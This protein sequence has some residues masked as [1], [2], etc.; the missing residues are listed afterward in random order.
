[1]VAGVAERANPE[2]Q[3]FANAK[4]DWSRDA[5]RAAIDDDAGEK[6]YP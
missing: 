2:A 1:M 5:V 3:P 6:L 4:G